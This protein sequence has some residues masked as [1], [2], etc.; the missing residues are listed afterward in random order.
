MGFP[1]ILDG[2]RKRTS[3]DKPATPDD[4]D[5]VGTKESSPP[6]A[7]EGTLISIDEPSTLTRPN[8]RKATKVR[9]AFSISASVSSFLSL[10]FLILVSPPRP[11]PVPPARPLTPSQVLIGNTYDKAVLRNLYFFKLDLADIIPTTVPNARLINSIAQTI[12]LHDFY[13]VGLWN[14]CEGY[15]NV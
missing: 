13:Q 14:F 15:E 1:S 10:I 3:V 11:D 7:A 9:K 4:G 12:G 6:S 8:L 2:L 5:A